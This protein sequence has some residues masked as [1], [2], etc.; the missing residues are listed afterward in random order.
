M[1]NKQLD[2]IVER[3]F[4]STCYNSETVHDTEL[5][6]ICVTFENLIEWVKEQYGTA[7][8]LVKHQAEKYK[9]KIG[10]LKKI[11]GQA[12]PVRNNK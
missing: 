9:K 10:Q 4:Q 7:K 8:E 6:A 11:N 1:N 3:Y 2:R 12:I 5:E